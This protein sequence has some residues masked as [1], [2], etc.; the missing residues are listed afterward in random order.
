MVY[1]HKVQL[2]GKKLRVPVVNI[3]DIRLLQKYVHIY[4]VFVTQDMIIKHNF[5]LEN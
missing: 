1:L 3:K 5:E 2:K 4:K